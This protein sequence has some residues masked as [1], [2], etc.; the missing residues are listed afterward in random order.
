MKTYVQ[1]LNE[2]V[3]E[4]G[5]E[6][7]HLTCMPNQI[8]KSSM[9][10]S[11]AKETL[12]LLKASEVSHVWN[13]CNNPPKHDE[14]VLCIVTPIIA[15]QQEI[16]VHDISKPSICFAH[17]NNDTWHEAKGSVYR[18][19]QH[20]TTDVSME[21]PKPYLWMEIPAMNYVLDEINC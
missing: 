8:G 6:N 5:I 2:Y 13:S 3:K 17:F 9:T 21:I 14:V 20:Y 4:R 18:K 16:S 12:M 15:M 7:T 11:I 19:G 10:E 1:Q